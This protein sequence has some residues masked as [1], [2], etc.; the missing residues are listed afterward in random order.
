M[1][2]EP[3]LQDVADLVDPYRAW[4]EHYH[5]CERKRRFRS[6]ALAE[7]EMR[8]LATRN[9]RKRSQKKKGLP[10]VRLHVYEHENHWHVGHESAQYSERKE[11]FQV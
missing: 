6:K 10:G 8:R 2:R 3:W 7:R 1:P 9:K 11:L 4:D 5:S